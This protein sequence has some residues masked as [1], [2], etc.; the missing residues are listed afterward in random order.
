MNLFG[1][2]DVSAS[3]L[4]AEPVWSK[5]F[6]IWLTP[7]RHERPKPVLIDEYDACVLRP[8]VRGF[9]AFR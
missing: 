3:A 6:E 8:Q 5:S 1:V 2:M 9:S 4:R 7:R